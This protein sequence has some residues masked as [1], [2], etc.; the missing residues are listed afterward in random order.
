[1]SYTGTII[2]E[3]LADPAAL[4]DVAIR[5][6]V[7]PSGPGQCTRHV[8]D[9]PDERAEAVARRLAGAIAPEGAWYADFKNE[10]THYVVFHGR[11]FRVAR[12]E[13]AGY[14]EPKAHGRTLG[15]PEHQLDFDSP[16]VEDA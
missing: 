2:A 3:S 8:V 7:S 4:A 10:R 9:I 12:D 11:V 15:I 5:R 13:P 14:E 6:T 1:V 16:D